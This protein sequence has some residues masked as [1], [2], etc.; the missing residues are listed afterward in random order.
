MDIGS[1]GHAIFGIKPDPFAFSGVWRGLVRA[2][3]GFSCPRA[4]EQPKSG[5]Q[6]RECAT[7]SPVGRGKKAHLEFSI[8]PHEKLLESS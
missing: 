3:G 6:N 5:C 7:L 2:K 4:N 8:D 1:K